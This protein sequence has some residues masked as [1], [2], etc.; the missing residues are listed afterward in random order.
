M[1]RDPIMEIAVAQHIIPK[2]ESLDRLLRY[3][4]AI[5]RSLTRALDRLDRLL[6]RRSEER[7]SPPVSVR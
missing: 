6:S 2:G 5:D 3:E 1:R 7:I 4:A